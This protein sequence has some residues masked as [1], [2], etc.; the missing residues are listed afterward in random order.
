MMTEIKNII[1]NLRTIHFLLLPQK[2]KRLFLRQ[3]L[4]L[5]LLLSLLLLPL[6]VCTVLLVIVLTLLLLLFS[7]TSIEPFFVSRRIPFAPF[8]ES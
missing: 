5:L 7:C 8:P 2:L 6:V 3:L 1:P 4:L